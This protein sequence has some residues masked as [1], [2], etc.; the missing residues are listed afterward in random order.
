MPASLMQLCTQRE[1][2]FVFF[3][4]VFFSVFAVQYILLVALRSVPRRKAGGN[5]CKVET[6]PKSAD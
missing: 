3:F 5:A 4:P 1:L 6:G 2:Y